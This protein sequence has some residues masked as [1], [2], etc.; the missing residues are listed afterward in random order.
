MFCPNC[1]TQL[2][3]DAAFCGECGAK[4]PQNRSDNQQETPRREPRNSRREPID[5]QTT[6]KGP[7]KKGDKKILKG[8]LIFFAICALLIYLQPR[9]GWFDDQDG[10]GNE[11]ERID[12]PAYQDEVVPN[13]SDEAPYLDTEGI[14]GI[15][16]VYSTTERPDGEDYCLW[17]P[18]VVQSNY[19]YPSG[20]EKITD[21]D[22]LTDGWKV[23]LVYDV[24]GKKGYNRNDLLNVDIDGAGSVIVAKFDWYAI[25]IDDDC[26]M[27]EDEPDGTFHG[28]W[29][30]GKMKLQGDF[31]DQRNITI[32]VDKFWEKDDKQFGIGSFTFDNMNCRIAMVRP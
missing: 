21:L 6:G 3:D 11:I 27:Y 26:Q 28:I 22:Q 2:P 16:S 4:I 7:D 18:D 10:A 25:T 31:L 13:N 5:N 19:A 14:E 17:Y 8:A 12:Q 15:V 32:V 24:D 23:M 20:S 9:G 29:E 1:G 30:N